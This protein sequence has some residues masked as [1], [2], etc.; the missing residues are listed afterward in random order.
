MNKAGNPSSLKR[1][2]TS[3][4][5]RVLHAAH[6]AT[7]SNPLETTAMT[8]STI[9]KKAG[10]SRPTAEDAVDDLVRFGWIEET[11][12]TMQVIRAG[13]PA[14]F[15]RFAASAGYVMGVDIARQWI[16]VFVADLSGKILTRHRTTVNSELDAPSRIAVTRQA[17]HDALTESGVASS[18]ILATTVASNGIVSPEGK[19]HKALMPGWTGLDLRAELPEAAGTVTFGNDMRVAI[20]G[21]SWIGAAQGCHTVVYLQAGL[22]IGTA[23]LVDGTSPL[24]AHGA[25]GE[26]APRDGRSVTKAYAR[27]VSAPI[28]EDSSVLKIDPSPVFQAA[29]AGEASAVDSVRDFSRALA[30]AIT[31]V[32][33]AVDPQVVVVGGGLSAV[34]TL[35]TEPIRELLSTV[36]AFEPQVVVSTLGEDAVAIGAIRLALDSAETKMFSDPGA[37]QEA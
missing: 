25:A 35:A 9:A 1:R 28:S 30:K 31:G 11:K 33:I 10:V 23:F 17:M 24:G 19:V 5:L 7:D 29:V 18:Q 34:S 21:E 3:E 32:V 12:P 14:R 37:L 2:N 8:V 4:V 15:V 6:R 20:M 27:L 13:R 26:M 36:C 16:H 22:R